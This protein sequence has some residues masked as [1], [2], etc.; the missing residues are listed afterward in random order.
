[1]TDA[2]TTTLEDLAE[3]ITQIQGDAESLRAENARLSRRLA[4]IEGKDRRVGE[5]TGPASGGDPD[6]GDLEGDGDHLVSRR[7]AF[8]ALGVAAVGGVGVAL[9]SALL[10]A[11]PAAAEGEA[12]TVGGIFTDATSTT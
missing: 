3:R 2:S 4:R 9:G 12:V 6:L 1:M 7:G 5:P 8:K 11:E 10:G